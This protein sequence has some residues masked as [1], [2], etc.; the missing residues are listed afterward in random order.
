MG[1]KDK[2]CGHGKPVHR[3][4]GHFRDSAQMGIR[5]P[6]AWVFPGRTPLASREQ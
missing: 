1:P 2:N 4:N 6:S 5:P 3:E